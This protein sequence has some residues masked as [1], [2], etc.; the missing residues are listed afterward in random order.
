MKNKISKTAILIL[1]IG[2]LSGIA[3]SQDKMDTYTM[4][5]FGK[6]F[7]INMSSIK[8]NGDYSLQ[9]HAHS[10]D[11]GSNDVMLIIKRD[12]MPT[13]R[14]ILDTAAFI[15][16]KW[17]VAAIQ[18]NVSAVEKEIVVEKIDIDA[19]F[20]KVDQWQF[21]VTVE[22]QAR[23]KV[24]NGTY[25]LIIGNT[26]KLQSTANPNLQSDGF[27]LVF[28]SEEEISSFISKVS[29]ESVKRFHLRK[30]ENHDI[31]KQ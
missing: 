21:D 14:A 13:F 1:L 9:I 20:M 27:Y 2:S 24:I 3:Y 4:N 16:N 25:L 26:E 11:K 5:N 19:A 31:F 15:Y 10:I 17:K 22:L 28:N 18:N 12:E 6:T 29:Q 23:F 8:S 7:E 30:T